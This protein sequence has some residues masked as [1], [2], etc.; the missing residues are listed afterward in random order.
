MDGSKQKLQGFDDDEMDSFMLGR[1]IW[2]LSLDVWDSQ[3]ETPAIP[4]HP[5]RCR[6]PFYTS[7]K[8]R[9]DVFK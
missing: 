7:G 2:I 4:I 1:S 5:P 3:Q 6:I 8:K 9:D